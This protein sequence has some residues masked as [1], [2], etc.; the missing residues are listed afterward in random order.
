MP[1]TPWL[2]HSGL[3]PITASVTWSGSAPSYNE[4]SSATSNHAVHTAKRAAVASTPRASSQ[5]ACVPV[6][7]PRTQ[8]ALSNYLTRL[9]LRPTR[10]VGETVNRKGH[11]R[12]NG[13]VCRSSFHST[14]GSG[15]GLVAHVSTGANRDYATHRRGNPPPT[16]YPGS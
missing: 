1:P 14:V 11:G 5:A 6:S 3:M 8:G 15:S 16:R 7:H 12:A 4:P 2:P 10:N 9:R 13:E